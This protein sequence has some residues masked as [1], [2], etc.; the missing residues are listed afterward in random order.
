MKGHGYVTLPSRQVGAVFGGLDVSNCAAWSTGRSA[1]HSLGTWSRG[2]I[3]SSWGLES[4]GVA[5]LDGQTS[6]VT[7]ACGFTEFGLRFVPLLF[8]L[9]GVW[10]TSL[11]GC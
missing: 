3:T 2:P 8:M 9:R 4:G 7:P 5:P 11:V 10:Y 1:I 6:W